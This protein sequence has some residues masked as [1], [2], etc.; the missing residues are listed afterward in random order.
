MGQPM[1]KE[2]FDTLAAPILAQKKSPPK[3]FKPQKVTQPVANMAV[4]TLAFL[5]DGTVAGTAQWSVLPQPIAV[6]GTSF[7]SSTTT[8]N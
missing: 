7:I 1:T 2:R 5:S 3:W 8:L 6:R 4:T